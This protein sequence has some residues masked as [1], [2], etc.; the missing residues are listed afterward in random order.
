MGRNKLEKSEGEVV[1]QKQKWAEARN[2]RRRDRYA[3]DASYQTSVNQRNRDSYRATHGVVLRD[4]RESINR[5]VEFGTKRH[6]AVNGFVEERLTFTIKELAEVAGGY[7]P[8]VFYRWH[9]E[10]KFPR[11]NVELV[12]V[13]NN[14]QTDKLVYTEAQVRRLLVILGAH[15]ATKQYL[16][17]TDTTT[18]RSLFSVMEEEK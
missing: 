13:D 4:C 6:V 10:E 8:I 15:Q 2:K 1:A 11:P 16:H 14:V 9:K 7:H 3:K 18:I 5:L 17:S 12:D